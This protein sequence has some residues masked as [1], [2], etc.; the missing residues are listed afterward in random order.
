MRRR[1]VLQLGLS[2][3]TA[4]GAVPLIGAQRATATDG[5][6]TFVYVSNAGTKDIYVLGMNRDTGELTMVEKVPVPGAEKTSL[7][8]LPM[9]LAPN[10][11]FIY[12]QLRSEPYPVSTFS[13]DHTS[14]KLT[15]LDVTPLV[16]QMAYI[17]VDKTGKHLL[18]ASYTAAKVAVYSIDA[19]YTVEGKATQIID[20]KPKAH[21]VFVDT[22]NRHVYVP[23]LGA[24]YVMQFKFDARTGILTLNDPP[25][26]ATKAGAGPRHFTIHSN[27]KWGYLITETTATIGT[28]SIEKDTG[29]LTEVAYV[30]TGDYNQK[31]SAFASDIHIT[32]NGKFL[33]GAVRTTSMLHG[34]KIDP[35]K[36]TLTGIGKWPT[37][38]TPRGFNIDAR[39]KFLLAVGMD[40]ASLTVHA[41]DPD[42]GELKN[43]KQY[44]MGK[45]PNWVE[46]VDRIGD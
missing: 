38:K 18:G 9:A 11:R 35:E 14:G 32:P 22:S 43:V 45:Q 5:A 26:V 29:T 28:Y 23:V 34:Y 15:H 7:V 21:C 17:N 30:D 39:G 25:T 33:Y 3:I 1:R 8:S 42:S 37:E 6:E 20:T 24:D 13:I 40:S 4:L 19:R 36:G 2:G 16:D 10:K 46:I 27:G 44:P 12:A 41:I 31:D